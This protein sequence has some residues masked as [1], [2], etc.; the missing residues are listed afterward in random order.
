LVAHHDCLRRA[1]RKLC[2]SPQDADDLVQ[3]LYVTLLGKQRRL[4]TRDADLGYLLRALR[5]TYISN[6]R[7]RRSRFHAAELAGDCDGAL[8]PTP[9][10]PATVVYAREIVREIARLPTEQRRTVTAVDIVGL[11]YGEAARALD[12]PVGTVM[13]RLHRGRGRLVAALAG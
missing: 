11:S 12:T 4:Q 10:S 7:K 3:D 5:N 8:V 2:P 13:S 6:L 1:A 9:V